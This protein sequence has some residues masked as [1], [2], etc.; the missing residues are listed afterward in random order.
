[1]IRPLHRANV[2]DRRS[3]WGINV[4]R[5]VG[6]IAVVWL[7]A[8]AAARLLIVNF[9][10][11]QADVIVVLSG[12]STYQERT[13]VAAELYKAGIAKRIVLTN[14]HM[15]G[16]WSRSEQRNPFF[17]ERARDELQLR[18]VPPSM[19][20]LLQ[21]PVSSTYDEALLIRRYVEANSYRSVLVVTSAYHS[22]RAFWM[23]NRVLAGKGVVV[24]IET[25]ATGWQ[26]PKP[27][28]W[29]FSLKGWQDVAAEYVKI[30][31][32]HLRY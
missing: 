24:G 28:L 16:S 21:E 1:M 29:W 4:L 26:T 25:A 19:I 14:D 18:G 30:A 17:Y 12:S 10:L 11:Y 20:D 7:F 15:Q 23:I 3:M 6:V 9:P 22:R 13:A 8:W 31:Y 5:L 32:Y 27:G 2:S